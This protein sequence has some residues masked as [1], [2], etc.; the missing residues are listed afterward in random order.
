M[1]PV[2]TVKLFYVPP[3]GTEPAQAG[4]PFSPANLDRSSAGGSAVALQ[5]NPVSPCSCSAGRSRTCCSLHRVLFATNFSC[6]YL[7]FHQ[8]IPEGR[9]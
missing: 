3:C 2:P 7:D 6:N 9:G 5:A 8:R 1:L 4:I